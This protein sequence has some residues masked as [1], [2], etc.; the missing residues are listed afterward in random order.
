MK[1][2]IK[3]IFKKL[4]LKN[5]PSTILTAVIEF[6]LLSDIVIALIK[7][8]ASLFCYLCSIF[9]AMWYAGFENYYYRKYL[10]EKYEK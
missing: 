6:I 7:R 8:E 9:L 1:Q 3:T 2:K 4:D 10:K 5:H